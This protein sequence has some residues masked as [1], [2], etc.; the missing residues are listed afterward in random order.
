VQTEDITESRIDKVIE[1]SIFDHLLIECQN[2][3]RP[4]VTALTKIFD[5]K[6]EEMDF[7]TLLGK[8]RDS[9]QIKDDYLMNPENKIR[10]YLYLKFS[11][12]K[13]IDT[14][15]FEIGME[16]KEG[17]EKDN[18]DKDVK[19]KK[20]IAKKENFLIFI[21]L[22]G[23]TLVEYKRKQMDPLENFFEDLVAQDWYWENVSSSFTSNYLKK[24]TANNKK[25]KKKRKNY[26]LVRDGITNKETY[27]L[28][29]CLGATRFVQKYL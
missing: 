2:M 27:T 5:L 29:V 10:K 22:H 24:E 20:L 28:E 6:N 26:F 8:L 21:D 13:S 17:K 19:E 18:K 12:G 4:E 14:D 25:N 23:P 15:Y 7:N 9:L 3:A 16:K 11:D 1:K